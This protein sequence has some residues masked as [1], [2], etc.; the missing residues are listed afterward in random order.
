MLKILSIIADITSILCFIFLVLQIINNITYKKFEIYDKDNKNNDTPN[1][2]INKFWI[3]ILFVNIKINEIF[4]RKGHTIKY[5][6]L[7]G[8]LI[9]VKEYRK[10]VKEHYIDNIINI[11]KF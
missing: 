8:M 1:G 6:E 3:Y 5:S 11:F 2:G 4:K 9:S 7:K 10:F